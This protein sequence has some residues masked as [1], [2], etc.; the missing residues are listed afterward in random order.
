MRLS[1]VVSVGLLASLSVLACSDPDDP[2][3]AGGA[4][5][6]A[7]EAAGGQGGLAAGGGGPSTSNGGS[8]GGSES[9]VAP[10]GAVPGEQPLLEGENAVSASASEDAVFRLD[11]SPN[12]HAGFFLRFA[13][14]LP[15]VTLELSRW[16]GRAE[17]VL[18]ITDAAAAFARS[19]PSIRAVRGP[20]G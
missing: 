16:D 2:L 20:S 19:R 13:A 3:A 18:A 12:E 14:G 5:G 11:L 15:G 6:D 17:Q 4:A 8:G 10:A 1:S 9:G 7:A